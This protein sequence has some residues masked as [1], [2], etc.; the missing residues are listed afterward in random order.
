VGEALF[1]A[2]GD[3]M[4]G[5][6]LDTAWARRMYG[7]RIARP[8]PLPPP[9]SLLQPIR[10]LVEDAAVV[11]VNVEG[12]VGEGPV[13]GKC[14]P[15]STRCYQFRQEV[16]AAAALR[17]L[18]PQGVVVGNVANN[19]AMDAGRDGFLATVEHLRGAGLLVTGVDTLPTVVPLPSGDTI[20]V[21]GFSTFS[22]GPDARDLDAVHRHVT[23]AAERYRFVVVTV[24]MGAE[25]TAAQRTRDERETF[26]GEDRGNPVGFARA[27]VAAGA[28][29][30]FGHGP[31]V[32]RAVEW[33]GDAV[34]VYSLG[35]LLT[36]GPFSREEPLNRGGFACVRLSRR[37]GVFWGELRGVVHR[38]PGVALPDSQARAA[39]LVDSLSAL[40]FPAT[41]A[42]IVDGIIF[43][44]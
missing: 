31:H 34:V 10:P 1:C 36:H 4:L 12:A 2:G 42:R 9:D 35:N 37:G 30:V 17:K 5:S 18:A 22:A 20:A 6:N 38:H 23:R 15:G 40:D 7:G 32:L 44:R 25:G 11:M 39:A 28:D 16:A 21:L 41:G 19:H 24:H 13:T 29:A 8:L 43:R 3:V 26:A 14:R 27:A 33:Q